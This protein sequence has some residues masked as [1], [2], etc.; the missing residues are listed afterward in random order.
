MIRSTN[1]LEIAIN[2]ATNSTRIEARK[3]SKNNT[4]S[5]TTTKDLD[6]RGKENK[7]ELRK[8]I[9]WLSRMPIYNSSPLCEL[10]KLAWLPPCL[11]SAEEPRRRRTRG[12]RGQRSGVPGE[13][14]DEPR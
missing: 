10:I 12:R 11:C 8:K 13:R 6:S 9:A 7:S 5:S 3:G 1:G 14:N 4:T 2:G